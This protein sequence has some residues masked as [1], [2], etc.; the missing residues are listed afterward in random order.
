MS[1]E[2]RI[3]VTGVGVVCPTGIGRADAWRN[4]IEGRSGIRPVSSFNPAPLPI[5][6][7]GEIEGFDP[8]LFVKPRKALKVMARDA[9]LALAA[10]SLARAEANF[11]PDGIDPE[12]VGVVFG[13]QIIRNEIEEVSK[14]FRSSTVDGEF[15][16]ERWGNEGLASCFPLEMLKLL[17]NMLGC[18][19]SIS[20][21]ARGPNNTLCM[22]EASGVLAAAEAASVIR[23][24]WAD[25][26]LAGA[27]SCRLN[28]YDFLRLSICDELSPAEPERASRPFDADRDGQVIGAGAGTL[29]LES[30]AGAERRGANILAELRGSGSAC[31]ARRGRL[32]T[33]PSP[34]GDHLRTA[35]RRAL[36][37]ARMSPADIGFVSAH[38]LSTRDGDRREAAALGDVLPGVPVFAPKSYF[39]NLEAACGAVEAGLAISALEAGRVPATL[40]YER[41]DPDCPIDVIHGRPLDTFK[42]ACVVLNYTRCGQAAA[43]VLSRE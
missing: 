20:Q 10:A 31:R 43:L 25:A 1:A 22:G 8:A 40:N 18:H 6:A 16:W 24:G 38:G 19:I 23:R 17:P 33:D 14:P 36:A 42:P 3:V 27:A 32:T 41:P 39:G 12:R 34:E 5:R 7:A 29:L 13:G 28:C 35:V 2:V 26:M 21:D 15:R 4:M 11:A 37:D 30:R 9:P